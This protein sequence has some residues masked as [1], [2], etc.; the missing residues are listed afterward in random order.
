MKALLAVAGIAA[1]VA[2]A[3]ALLLLR[4]APAGGAP[5]PAPAGSRNDRRL[6]EFAE[7]I[8]LLEAR[9]AEVEGRDL[10]APAAAA[11]PA[12]AAPSPED[13]AGRE[14]P[15]ELRELDRRLLALARRNSKGSFDPHEDEIRSRAARAAEAIGLGDGERLRYE[16][17]LRE[18]AARAADIAAR[19]REALKD[20][21]HG[22][23]P[24]EK[25]AV[26]LLEQERKKLDAG[27]RQALSDLVGRERW[28][29]NLQAEKDQQDKER[30]LQ[31]LEKPW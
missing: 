5:S 9:L 14:A 8:A 6:E 21:V 23:T 18:H 26:A 22:Y 3:S 10:P 20:T 17:I 12:P 1:A 7:R 19:A 16:E 27:T 15:A 29:R 13:A 4:A 24:A 11:A 28:Q 31:R 2:L 25:A 30:A